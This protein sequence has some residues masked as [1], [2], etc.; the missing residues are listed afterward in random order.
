LYTVKRALRALQSPAYEKA[1]KKNPLLPQVTDRQSAETAFK[2]LP[3]SMLALRV[4]KLNHDHDHDEHE[5]HSHAKKKRVKG[6]WEVNIVS[7]QDTE[8]DMYY[9]WL[10]D[11]PAWK[12]QIY[13]VSALALVMTL[14][15]FPLWPL[16]LRQGA[17]Y[18]SMGF[19]GLIVA[20]FV[21]S[22]FR[23]ILFCITM[24]SHPP[25]LW[26]FPNLF[27]DVGF[28]DSF[29]PVWAMQEVRP[30]L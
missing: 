21:M 13:A 26:L 11:G 15:M 29:K 25:G 8:D 5:G 6:L 19:F 17:W 20:F 2:Q 1:R 22:I 12:Q 10:Y 27:E 16:A 4:E 30:R 18:L 14:V 23:L 3:L 7:Q 9:M 24:F 28:F